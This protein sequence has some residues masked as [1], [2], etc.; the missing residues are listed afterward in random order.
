LPSPSGTH[1][2]WAALE[3]QWRYLAGLGWM[4]GP[5]YTY[6]MTTVGGQ[7]KMVMDQDMI[8]RGIPFVPSDAAATGS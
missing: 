2:E 7:W 1:E 4:V 3:V 8:N 6:R 5:H